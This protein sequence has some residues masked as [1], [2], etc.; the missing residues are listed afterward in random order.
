MAV[1]PPQPGGTRLRLDHKDPMPF[2]NQPWKSLYVFQRLLTTLLL[3]PIWVTYY[4]LLPRR[5]RPR[6]S[7]SLKQIV[8]V[9][10]YRRVYK[11][12]ELAGVKWGTRDPDTSCDNK[13]LKETRFEWIDPLPE[14]LRSGIVVDQQVPFNNVGVFIWPKDCPPDRPVQETAS[15]VAFAD[16]PD[17]EARG[18]E[19][20]VIGI[21]LHGGGYCHMSAHE[22]AGTSRIP[23]RL[24]KV[25]DCPVYTQSGL[26]LPRTCGFVRR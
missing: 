14:D 11:V 16:A 21:F 3:V 18:D 5:F 9:N 15:K 13:T 1:D 20:P 2:A 23:R 24:M 4:A 26:H 8:C 25:C 7:W 6:S 22:D 10:F 19:P 12:T 17:V